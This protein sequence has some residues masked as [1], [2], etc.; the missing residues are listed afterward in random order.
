MV[1][2][3]PDIFTITRNGV[4]VWS[5]AE[6]LKVNETS[7]TVYLAL[8]S[9]KQKTITHRKLNFSENAFFGI[10]PVGKK[11]G[12]RWD[13]QNVEKNF[14]MIFF[15]IF[16]PNGISIHVGSITKQHSDLQDSAPENY[17]K[18]P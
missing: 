17:K 13:H 8:V 15:F 4:N 7:R 18:H 10:H 11:S 3:D 1:P 2:P 6:L 9:S 5:A 12:G 16:T 14:L